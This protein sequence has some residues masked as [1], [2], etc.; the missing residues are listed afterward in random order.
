MARIDYE[1]LVQTARDA[2]LVADCA[3]R[4]LDANAAAAE[5]LGWPRAD[6]IGQPLAAIMP[7]RYRAAHER[8]MRRFTTTRDPTLI[9][10]T[11]QVEALRRDGR[12][13]RVELALTALEDGGELLFGAIMRDLSQVQRLERAVEEASERARRLDEEVRLREEFLSTASHEL[14]TPVS[15]LKMQIRLMERTGADA[16]AIGRLGRQAARLERLV[17]HMLDAS[18]VATGHLDVVRERV[19]LAALAR[20]TARDVGAMAPE[21]SIT[22][23]APGPV[24]VDG[25]PDRLR[26][27]LLNLFDNA[28]K[29]SP[30]PAPIRVEAW[31]HDRRALLRVSDRGL[32][33]PASLLPRLFARFSRESSSRVRAIPGL[34]VGLYI[35]R[36]ILEAHGGAI[37]VDSEEGRGAVFTVDLPAR[38]EAEAGGRPGAVLVVDDDADLLELVRLTLEDASIPAEVAHNGRE[39]LEALRRSRPAVVLLDLMMPVMDGWEC[40]R[41]IRADT[42]TRDLPVV[43]FSGDHAVEEQ[44]AKLGADAALAKPVDIDDLLAV[45]RRWVR[46]LPAA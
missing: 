35:V 42:T 45:L 37:R 31:R 9:G 17:A 18:R 5:M 19:D 40:Y 41:H 23:D 34:G 1:R 2:I 11:I 36:A 30:Q 7:E 12:E 8:G 27:V 33:I 28:V 13:V 43:V 38:A 46:P 15:S 32:G 6:L 10:R 16:D 44:A 25:D 29:Y 22:I 14:R 4:V 24:E 39:A 21:H 3:G 26:Q 20:E